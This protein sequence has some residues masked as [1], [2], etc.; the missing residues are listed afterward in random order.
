MRLSHVESWLVVRVRKY[1]KGECVEY[2]YS[3]AELRGAKRHTFGGRNY[4]YGVGEC[5]PF[6]SDDKG[7]EGV[8]SAS[9]KGLRPVRGNCMR[10]GGLGPF[11]ILFLVPTASTQKST[12]ERSVCYFRSLEDWTI[13]Q[14]VIFAARLSTS[15]CLSTRT[16]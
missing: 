2:A 12:H 1:L 13:N 8:V 16:I 9:A 5:S 10:Q 11:T 7:G 6:D 4:I 3:L 14:L 15:Y